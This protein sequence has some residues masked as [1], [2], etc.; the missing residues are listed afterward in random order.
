M[1]KCECH[2]KITKVGQQKELCKTGKST[3]AKVLQFFDQSQQLQVEKLFHIVHKVAKRGG[4]FSSFQHDVR[5][6]T[7]IVA[8]IGTELHTEVI[9]SVENSFTTCGK[10][11]K[12]GEEDEAVWSSNLSSP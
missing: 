9:S 8:D 5:V 4:P 2:P 11:H 6:T 7:K 3:E 10:M 12:A 1:K